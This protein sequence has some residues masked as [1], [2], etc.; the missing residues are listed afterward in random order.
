MSA[1]GATAIA[2]RYDRSYRAPRAPGISFALGALLVALCVVATLFIG[3]S[4]G[5]IPDEGAGPDTAGT[6]ASISPSTVR[7]GDTISFTV[8]G[9]PAGETVYIKIDDGLSCSESAVHGACVYH[10]QAI[11]AGGTVSG[12]F[13][14]PDDLA[15]GAHWLRFLASQEKTDAEG[16]Y[17]GVLGFTLRGGSDFTVLAS[18]PGATTGSAADSGTSAAAGAGEDEAVA[19]AGGGGAAADGNGIPAGQIATAVPVATDSAA[20]SSS[21]PSEGSPLETVPSTEAATPQPSAASID[22]PVSP[23]GAGVPVWGLSGLVLALGLALFAA[24]RWRSRR[25]SAS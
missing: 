24:Y 7:A 16:N 23:V 15:V 10:Q 11:P 21:P 8:T 17:L 22:G 1:Q 25:S 13:V 5:A 20:E 9:F 19:D 4:A 14:L 18:E 2:D 6:S 3:T 12:T